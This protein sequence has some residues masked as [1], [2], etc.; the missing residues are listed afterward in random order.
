[1]DPIPFIYGTTLFF[2]GLCAGSFLNVVIYRIPHEASLLAPPSSCPK[3]GKT[4]AWYDNIPVLSWLILDAHCRRCAEPISWR[5]PGVE[6]LTGLLWA[7]VGVYMSDSYLPAPARAATMTAIALFI[8]LLIA[9]A[10][11][12]YDLQIIPD[13]LSIGGT[14]LA[15]VACMGLPHLHPYWV[16]RVPE[17]PPPFA[18]LLGGVVGA[19]SGAFF[20]LGLSLMGTLLFR[21]QIRD[22]QKKDPDITTAI[23]FGD[24]KLMAFVGAFLGWESVLSAFFLGTVFGA[25]GG[26][27]DKVRTGAWPGE[28]GG[29][30]HALRHRWH[31]GDSVL[32]YGPFLC[33]GAVVMAFAHGPILDWVNGV[34]L[35]LITYY[36]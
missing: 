14:I 1:M 21:R 23:G 16:K 2:M 29:T 5:Y 12:D 18:S 34:L 35:P 22:A 7:G 13:E 36:Y 24:I 6:L 32:P 19:L 15:L 27:F 30:I 9:I 26:I 3:C 31:T 4:I 8:S 33:A 20:V 28:P 25:F 10:F 17:L 11:I